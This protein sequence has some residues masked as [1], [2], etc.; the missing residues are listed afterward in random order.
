MKTFFVLILMGTMALEAAELT[1]S[2][3]EST[4]PEQSLEQELSQQLLELQNQI[5]DLN[6]HSLDHAKLWEE[7]AKHIQTYNSLLPRIDLSN[8]NL[9]S[10]SEYTEEL[11]CL[12]NSSNYQL[13]IKAI[14]IFK[15]QMK[16]Y[17]DKLTSFRLWHSR[18]FGIFQS[19]IVKRTDVPDYVKKHIEQ[20]LRSF[21]AEFPHRSANNLFY[22]NPSASSAATEY[23]I[24]KLMA[25]EIF[26]SESYKSCLSCKIAIDKLMNTYD[27]PMPQQDLLLEAFI[28]KLQKGIS[29][30]EKSNLPIDQALQ[31]LSVLNYVCASLTTYVRSEK[32]DP[33]FE[34]IIQIRGDLT[35]Y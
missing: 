7:T 27:L 3:P 10:L 9:R 22:Q 6:N 29:E 1:L 15:T 28:S 2:H 30:L 23:E 33:L 25:S 4:T 26:K 14:D 18:L 20:K 32:I 5:V 17:P 31:Q 24:E 34:K 12:I 35:S 19:I 11:I 8:P 13:F 16:A 21:R